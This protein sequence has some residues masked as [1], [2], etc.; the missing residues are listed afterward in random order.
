MFADRKLRDWTRAG[1]KQIS[2]FANG[3]V[4]A[5]H[6]QLLAVGEKHACNIIRSAR[7]RFIF[8]QVWRA[9]ALGSLVSA[10]GQGSRHVPAIDPLSRMCQKVRSSNQSTPVIRPIVGRTTASAP[11]AYKEITELRRSAQR[12][13]YRAA[14]F[15]MFASFA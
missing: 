15:T 6:A 1:S 10:L 9:G 12:Y 4:D 3:L 13:R 11:S 2:Q 14:A 5:I 8:R 7:R